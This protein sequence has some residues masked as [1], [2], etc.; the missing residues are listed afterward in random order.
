MRRI[1]RLESN[2][3]QYTEYATQLVAMYKTLTNLDE[4]TRKT[5]L[6][7]ISRSRNSDQPT[8]KL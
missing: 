7:L 8:T 4:P 2:D 5:C 3:G 6:F 1:A